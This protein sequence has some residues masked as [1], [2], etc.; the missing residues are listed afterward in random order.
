M[1]DIGCGIGTHAVYWAQQGHE[2]WAEDISPTFIEEAGKAAQQS[3]VLVHF[4]N[5]PI[6]QLDFK[7]DFD[8]VSAIEFFPQGSSLMKVWSFLKP[9]GR[10]IFDVRNPSN[11]KSKARSAN[12]RTW[13]ERDGKFYLERHETFPDQDRRENVWITIDPANELIEE[14]VMEGKASD[15]KLAMFGSAGELLAFGFSRIEFRTMEGALYTEGEEPYWLWGVAVK[16][17][18]EQPPAQ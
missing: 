17:K 3:G 11:A 15:S 7:D 5:C 4:L 2:V 1:L 10:L 16:S 8:V 9:G 6:E 14:R 13:E 18:Q 12:C